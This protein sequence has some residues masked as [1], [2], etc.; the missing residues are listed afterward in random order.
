MQ[1]GDIENH[2]FTHGNWLFIKYVNPIAAERASHRHGS[3]LNADTLLSVL[4]LTARLASNM[5]LQMARDGSLIVGGGGRGGGSAGGGGGIV[6]TMGSVGSVSEEGEDVGLG[7][8]QRE[9]TG[10][11]M[12]RNREE[13]RLASGRYRVPEGE[14]GGQGLYLQPHRRKSL[15]ER[16]VEYFFSY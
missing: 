14:E 3:F 12:A 1:C 10:T 9:S 5:N 13:A 15:C 8:R 2:H 16:L 4:V 6:R 7:L 11:E